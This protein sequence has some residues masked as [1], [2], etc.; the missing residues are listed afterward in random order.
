MDI[1]KTCSIR[2]WP[3]VNH[4]NAYMSDAETYIFRHELW[5]FAISGYD[6][7]GYDLHVKYFPKEVVGKL[8]SLILEFNK[9]SPSIP[10]IINLYSFRNFAKA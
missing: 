8:L 9:L 5:N 6:V 4:C 2:S 7:V 10:R 1:L 3:F